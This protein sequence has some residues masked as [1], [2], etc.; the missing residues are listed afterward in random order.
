MA[1]RQFLS[2]LSQYHPGMVNPAEFVKGW[3]HHQEHTCW[4]QP[5]EDV[6]KLLAALETDPGLAASACLCFTGVVK[7]GEGLVASYA[8]KKGK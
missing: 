4:Y 1:M 3:R 6:R 5:E 7:C 8:D 2:F